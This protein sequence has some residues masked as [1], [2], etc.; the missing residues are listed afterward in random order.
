MNKCKCD[1][2][3]SKGYEGFRGYCRRHYDQINHDGHIIDKRNRTDDNRFRMFDDFALM[4]ITDRNDNFKFSVKIDKEDVPR[5]KGTH[6]TENGKGY[7][8]TFKDGCTTAI[9]LHRFLLNYEGEL[10]VDHINRDRSDNRKCNLRI[11]NHSLNALNKES[12]L[13]NVRLL[14]RNL[15]K[16]YFARVAI[17]RKVLSKYF[18]TEEEAKAWVNFQKKKFI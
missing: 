11:I 7:V 9:Y 16:K 1:F 5:L 2:C 3:N 18:E 6:W 15:K 4:E 12:Q 13:G 17:N 10:D 14:K 8:R